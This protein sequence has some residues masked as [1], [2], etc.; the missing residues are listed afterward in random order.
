M[1]DFMLAKQIVDELLQIVQEKKLEHIKSAE[2]EIG[3]VV[4]A[5]D[6]FP[7][8]AEEINLENLEFGL[9]G[10]AKNTILKDV[11]FRL[12]KVE[13]GDWKITNIEV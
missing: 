3:T 7:E 6:D 10:I 13:G 5:H 11:E 2:I 8:H 9:Q 1:H 12:K 4:L